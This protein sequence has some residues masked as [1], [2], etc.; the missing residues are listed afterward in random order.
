[1]FGNEVEA[2]RLHMPRCSAA[3]GIGTLSPVSVLGAA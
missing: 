3:Q 2:I 1:M